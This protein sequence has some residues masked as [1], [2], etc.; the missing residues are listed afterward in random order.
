MKKNLLKNFDFVVFDVD[1]TLVNNMPLIHQVFAEILKKELGISREKSIKFLDSRTGLPIQR[2]FK[3]ILAIYHKD[4]N[5]KKITDLFL[6]K[7]RE[8]TSPPFEGAKSVLR[9]LRKNLQIFSISGNSTENIKISLKKASLINYF[10]LVL[11][12]EKFPKG[13]KHI[14]IFAKKVGLSF[15]E[16]TSRTFLVGDGARDMAIAY[17]YGIYAIGIANTVSATKLYDSGADEVIN[18][19]EELIK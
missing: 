8:G 4:K 13:K 9:E 7:V 17:K 16:F 2:I 14:E 12:S 5:T 1:G 3:E 18:N 15:R 10:D 11:G 19:L 6:R